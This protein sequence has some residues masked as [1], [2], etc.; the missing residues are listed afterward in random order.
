MIASIA[1]AGAASAQQPKAAPTA[2]ATGAATPQAASGMSARMTTL[3]LTRC[4][5][6]GQHRDGG[7]WMCPGLPGYEIYFAE[8]DLR[9]MIAYGKQAKEQRAATQTLPPFNSIFKGRSDRTVI[10]WR[11]QTKGGELVPHA[12]IV[13][14]FTDAGDSGPGPRLRGQVLVVSKV[15]PKDGTEA[16][17]VA[18]IDALANKD[19]NALAL[20]AADELAPGFDCKKEPTVIGERG[21]SPMGEERKI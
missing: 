18:Y 19:A 15:G 11:G 14:Y 3:L 7:S 12:T 21:K 2:P 16:C 1:L 8:G 9:Q 5:R 10:M 13:R 20:K 4:R 17:H 6:M